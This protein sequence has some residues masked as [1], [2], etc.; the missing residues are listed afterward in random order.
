MLKKYVAAALAATCALSI[1]QAQGGRG[2]R[3]QSEQFPSTRQFADSAQAQQ[4]VAAAMTIAG[5]DLAA[6][7]KAFCTPTGPQRPALVRQAAGPKPEPDRRLEPIRVFDNLYYLGFSDVGAWAIPTSDGSILFDTLNNGDEARDVIAGGLEKVGLDPA[8]IRY[9]II[10]HGHNDHT[11][12]GV[13]LQNTYKPRI[14]MGA[15]DWKSHIAGE[16]PDRPVMTHDSNVIDGQRLTLGDTTVTLA[17]TPGHTP[18]TIAMLLPVK[19]QGRTHTALLLS[20]TQM[21]TRQSLAAFEHVFNDLAKKQNAE[22]ALGSHPGT[23]LSLETLEALGRAYP[24][25]PHPLLYGP[26]RFA[27]YLD[28][29]LECGRARLA[30]LESKE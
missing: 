4:H 16:R 8:Q 10:G 11:G 7:A 5:V 29:I 12:G 13:Y 6:E 27:R 21:P 15:P 20:G 22:A 19:H 26:Q 30:A 2:G 24:S 9:V 23:L 25:G 18:G 14:L 3:G 28:I 17:L 1:A